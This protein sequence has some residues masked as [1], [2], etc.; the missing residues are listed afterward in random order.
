[1]LVDELLFHLLHEVGKRWILEYC[2]SSRVV[3]ACRGGEEELRGPLLLISIVKHKHF[4]TGTIFKRKHLQAETSPSKNPSTQQDKKK[5]FKLTSPSPQLTINS[6]LALQQRHNTPNDRKPQPRATRKRVLLGKRRE[7]L[8]AQE[9]AR[10]TLPRIGDRER[11]HGAG[12]R[13]AAAGRMQVLDLCSVKAD[14]HV[15]V[16]GVLE[17]V[18]EEV[19]DDAAHGA[20]LRREV[21]VLDVDVEDHGHLGVRGL[22]AADGRFLDEAAR[23]RHL[24]FGAGHHVETLRGDVLEDVP[25]EDA[26]YYFFADDGDVYICEEVYHGKIGLS[27]G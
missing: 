5:R 8:R 22:R 12:D 17:G 18:A 13:L 23:V 16:R 3:W 1:M 20:G 10:D 21:V 27:E 11:D 19:H 4:Q 26:L 7:Q 2:Q 6:D 9:L 14:A 25:C 15:A 24:A